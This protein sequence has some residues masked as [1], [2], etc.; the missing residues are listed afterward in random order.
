MESF[1]ISSFFCVGIFAVPSNAFNPKCILLGHEPFLH[2]FSHNLMLVS[3]AMLLVPIVL[4][5][6][7]RYSTIITDVSVMW[8]GVVLT[9]LTPVCPTLIDMLS[10][11]SI[12]EHCQWLGSSGWHWTKCHYI[13]HRTN[14][15]TLWQ[16]KLCCCSL[17]SVLMGPVSLLGGTR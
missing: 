3:D 8:E 5:S 7:I 16:Q 2:R 17:I 1:Y 13:A 15:H 14:L 10:A 9:T 6:R 11:F 12:R 4:L